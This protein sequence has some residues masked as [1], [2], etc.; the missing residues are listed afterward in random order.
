[1]SASTA[2]RSASPGAR[3]GAR[4]E[5]ASRVRRRVKAALGR[6][7]Y[8]TGLYRLF[9]RG[10]AVIVLF[11]RVDDR[12]DGDPIT[13]SRSA[14]R[15][16]CT[17]FRRYF[18]VVSFG[19]LL[20]KLRRGERIDRHLAIT[21]DDGYRDNAAIAAP[22]LLSLGLPA[23]FFV[24]TG[25]VETDRMA[26]WDAEQG[27]PS[28][29]MT[30]EHVRRLHRQGFEIGA[31]TVNH[32]DLGVVEG[33]LADAE[34]RGSRERLERELSAPVSFFSYPFGRPDS[35][36]EANR[37][38]V[39]DAGFECCV[40]AFG[41]VIAPVTDAFRARRTPISSWFLSPYQFG[42]EVMWL[43]TDAVHA[44]A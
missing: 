33:E 2:A 28:E 38:R 42:F 12:F 27:I 32:V 19:E 31:H 18:V 39:R 1:M 21:F 36:T 25:F 43:R 8:W 40:S 44:S 3:P 22:E 37:E 34:I 9:F 16:F 24:A 10:K 6:L 17:F 7:A 30:W 23:C 41:G 29:W 13:C 4:P 5:L 20:A 14:F 35:I 11:H 15:A 26:P